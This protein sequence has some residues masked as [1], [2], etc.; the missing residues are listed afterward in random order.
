MSL[1]T[2]LSQNPKKYLIFDLD[3]TLARLEI[4]WSD[5]FQMLFS[6]VKSI[7]PSLPFAMPENAHDYFKLL[8]EVVTKQGKSAKQKLDK[9]VEEYE[10][11][12]YHGYTPYPELVSFIHAQKNNYTFGLWTSNSTR[13]IQDFLQKE[14]LKDIFKHII[15]MENVLFTKPN[16]EGFYKIYERNNLKKEYLM[17]GDSPS[18]ER[19]AQAADIDFFRIDYFSLG[20]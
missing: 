13:T 17:I 7:D 12:H 14:Q 15:A 20:H 3:L 16:P 2:Y 5:V 18:D 19:A 11:V 8:N 10:R 6:E 1:E 4:D 9:A